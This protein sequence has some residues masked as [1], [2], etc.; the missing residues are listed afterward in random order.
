MTRFE[1]RRRVLAFQLAD[2]FLGHL[3]RR[4]SYFVMTL[5]GWIVATAFP[6]RIHGLF[7]NLRQV[8]PEYTDAQVTDL[9]QRN[10]KNYGKFWV[11]LFKTPR[12]DPEYRASLARIDGL[13]N[14][15]DVLDR[16]KGC[17][18]I[19][20]HTGGWEGCVSVWGKMPGIR[21]SLIAE[22]LEPPE[23]WR[24]VQALR[25]S[26]GMELIPL[27]RTAPRDILRRLKDNQ[28]VA[29]A[30]DRDV[31]G[32]GK[33]YQFFG[34]MASIPTGVFDLA[35]RTGAGLLPVLCLRD[36]DDTYTI[37]GMEPFWVSREEGAVDAAVAHALRVFE[38]SIRRYPDQWHVMEPIWTESA[39]AEAVP[40]EPDV[41]AAVRIYPAGGGAELPNEE[42]RV[43]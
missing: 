27:T 34:A 38:A 37:V 41:A 18:A 25:Q 1:L 43:G 2:F 11:D 35:Q 7:E 21:A 14:L 23:L 16:G 3:P 26:T 32:T 19:S 39:A 40:P 6:R 20:I 36:P 22:V 5:V 29:A 28:V 30:I 12:L 33:P 8:F 13:E 24:R 42:A 15:Q 10:A 31:T 17:I 4:V 9:M